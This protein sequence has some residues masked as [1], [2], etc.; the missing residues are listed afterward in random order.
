MWL[1]FMCFFS[2]EVFSRAIGAV[3]VLDA[4]SRVMFMSCFVNVMVFCCD[5]GK[6]LMMLYVLFVVLFVC[7]V[8]VIKFIAFRTCTRFVYARDARAR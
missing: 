1:F 4:S 3:G 2:R 8:V 6:L 7:I 5:I